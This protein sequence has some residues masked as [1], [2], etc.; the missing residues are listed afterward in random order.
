M[1]IVTFQCCPLRLAETRTCAQTPALSKCPELFFTSISA[2]PYPAHSI[3]LSGG[4]SDALL[5]HS[6]G[7]EGGLLLWSVT[8]RPSEE[9]QGTKGVGTERVGEGSQGARSGR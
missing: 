4:A 2:K 8:A 3:G 1:L 5:I 7:W 6:P 9:Q